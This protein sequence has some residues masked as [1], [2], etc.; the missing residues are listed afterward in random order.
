MLLLC[1][2][3]KIYAYDHFAYDHDGNPYYFQHPL[4]IKHMDMY[5]NTEHH[6]ISYFRALT[7]A[8]C[9]TNA[10]KV[11]F[12]EENGKRCYEDAK[13]RCWWLPSNSEREKAYYNLLDVLAS[14]GEPRSKIIISIINA[15][16]QYCLDCSEEWRYINT[17]LHWSQYYFEMMEFHQT[18]IDHGYP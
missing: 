6:K 3:S 17:K 2:Y 18:L 15:L 16:A 7:L 12:Y 13:E 9:K 4:A 14:P 8:N 11:Q 5:F 10:Q 1:G